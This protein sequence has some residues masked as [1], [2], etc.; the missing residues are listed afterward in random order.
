[1]W[2]RIL[3]N[4]CSQDH[5]QHTL[6]PQG[7]YP[8]HTKYNRQGKYYYILYILQYIKHIPKLYLQI[9]TYINIRG[10]LVYFLVQTRIPD[11]QQPKYTQSKEIHIFYRI[12]R[13][14]SSHLHIPNMQKGLYHKYGNQYRRASNRNRISK[15]SLHKRYSHLQLLIYRSY[16]GYYIL[17]ILFHY[18]I[19][20]LYTYMQGAIFYLRESI[21]MLYIRCH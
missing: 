21:H 9:L 2:K 14:N 3:S 15:I 17:R 20:L 5:I 7:I 18:Q 11:I 1:M 6:F 10:N 4:L 19:T 8:L 12:H 13:L 16:K